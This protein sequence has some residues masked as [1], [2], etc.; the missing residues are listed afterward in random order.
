MAEGQITLSA[1]AARLAKQNLV[2]QGPTI[3][4]IT[5]ALLSW[6]DEIFPDKMPDPLQQHVAIAFMA[7]Q[8]SVVRKLRDEYRRQNMKTIR[9]DEL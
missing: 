1:M 7:G 2:G 6:L 4:P 5:L 9:A 3:P 8:V